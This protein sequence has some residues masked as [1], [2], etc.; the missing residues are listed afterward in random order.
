MAEWLR[1]LLMPV[2]G[3][4]QVSWLEASAGVLILVAMALTLANRRVQQR[5]L[6]DY[7]DSGQNGAGVRIGERDV[8]RQTERL[9]RLTGMLGNVGLAATSAPSGTGT[10]QSER[11]I[12]FIG[13]ILWS[14]YWDIWPAWRDFRSNQTIARLLREERQRREAERERLLGLAAATMPP[15][16]SAS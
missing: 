13:A 10:A 11:G 3:W 4:S 16:E 15:G 14:W 1:F 6:D 2:P 5:K 9:W 8:Q 12:I 7:V